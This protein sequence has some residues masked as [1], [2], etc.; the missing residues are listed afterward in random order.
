MK[1]AFILM[2]DSVGIGALP[3]AAQFNDAGSNTLKHIAEVCASGKADRDSIRCGPLALHSLTR[4]GLNAAAKACQG[5]DIP[6]LDCHA[7]DI[8]GAYG[9]ASELSRGKDTPSGH[10]EAAGVPV[11]FDWGY[12]PPTYPSFPEALVQAFIRETQVPG[13]LGNK[14]ASGTEIIEEWGEESVKTGKP[15]VYTS[16]DSVF[17]IAAHEQAFGLER[18]Y[19]VCKMTRKLVDSYN[20]GRVIARPFSGTTGNYHRTANRKDYSIPP[21]AW[22]LLDKL[23]EA[24]K[25]VIGIGKIPDIFAHRGFTGE[26]EAHGNEELFDATLQA[27]QT[28]SDQTLVFTNFV[29]FD[30]LY[31]HRRD[32]IG[33]AKALEDFD[34]RLLQ[35]EALLKDDDLAIITADHGCDPTFRGTDHTREYVPILI[36][37]PKIKPVFIG[38]RNTFSDIAQTLAEYFG[39]S[40]FPQGESFLSIVSR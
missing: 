24:K 25:Q 35:I 2:L 36:F 16:A 27:A 39:V 9:F 28:I 38:K 37:G 32:V 23:V 14:H 7:I 21:P 15:I 3:D 18:L 40:A 19:Q 34:Q 12:F 33:Y 29:D 11:L 31:G 22:T 6:G 17:Q 26:I 30:M 10:W 1:R 8:Q 5:S 13:I 4:L 20:I